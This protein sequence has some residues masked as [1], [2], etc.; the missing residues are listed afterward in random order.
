[1]LFPICSPSSQEAFNA[2]PITSHFIP[3]PL[4][5]RSPLV[6]YIDTSKEKIMIDMFG[7]PKG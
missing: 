5:G 3:Y 4:P 2:F 6:T 7:E 1:M